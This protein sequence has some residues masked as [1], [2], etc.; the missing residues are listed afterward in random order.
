MTYQIIYVSYFI[1]KTPL[2]GKHSYSI[3]VT[4][5]LKIKK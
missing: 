2:R 3:H 5:F 1:F 4:D